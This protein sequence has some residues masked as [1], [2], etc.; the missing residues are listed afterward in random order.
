MTINNVEFG[1]DDT[2]YNSPITTKQF[3]TLNYLSINDI[4]NSWL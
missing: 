1:Y 3:W 2:G 4:Y